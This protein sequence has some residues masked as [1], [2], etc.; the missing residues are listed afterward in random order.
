MQKC[1]IFPID[2]YCFLSLFFFPT[3]TLLHQFI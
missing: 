1:N 2:T 3:A